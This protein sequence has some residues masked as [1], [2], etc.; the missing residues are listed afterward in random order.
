MTIQ[1]KNKKLGFDPELLGVITEAE[2]IKRYV[3]AV[4]PIELKE[5]YDKHVKP[6]QKKPVKKK[7]ERSDRD[8]GDD[9]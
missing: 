6:L 9:K 4:S 3:K 2:F 5:L 7:V 8:S 1:S